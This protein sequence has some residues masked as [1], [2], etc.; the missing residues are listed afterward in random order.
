MAYTVIRFPTK[1]KLGEPMAKKCSWL[2]LKWRE[3]FGH[4]R[5]HITANTIRFDH[6]RRTG[7]T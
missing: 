4:R 3:W 7:R 5:K 1:A 2:T 6:A